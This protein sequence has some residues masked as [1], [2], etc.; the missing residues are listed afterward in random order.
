MP[1]SIGIDRAIVL[2]GHL[3]YRPFRGS[4]GIEDE[5][6]AWVGERPLRAGDAVE[7]IDAAGKILMP[8]L[9]NGHCH[10]ELAFARGMGD[11]LTL[12]EQNERFGP[13]RWFRDLVDDDDRFAS[14]C[15]TYCEALLSGTTF[16]CENMFWS[17]GERSVEAMRSVG[18][19]GALTE[20]VRHDFADP[21]RLLDDGELS[22]LATRAR[23]G[24]LVPL[25]GGPSEEDFEPGR[26]RRVEEKRSR[27]DLLQTCHLAETRWRVD[28][29]ERLY[30]RTPIGF[31]EEL[32]CLG[33]RLIGSHVVHATEEDVALLA[34]RG[35]KVVNTPLSEMKIA[36]GIAPVP[37]LLRAGVCVSLGTDGALWNNSNDLFREMKGLALVQTVRRGIRSLGVA[38]VLD[39][40]TVSGARVFGL[41]REMGTVEVGKRAD[42]VLLDAEQAHLSPLRLGAHENVA[43]TVVFCAT[44][45][46]V[47]DVLVGGRPAVRERRIQGVDLADIRRKVAATSEKVAAAL[48]S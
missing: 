29:I 12:A 39:M 31:L 40:A 13:S 3:R 17:L 44:G 1:F 30:G 43:S 11:D 8:G 41:E 10:G 22:A 6:I 21:D 37:E 32:G 7:R 5:R 18:I 25:L 19:R 36:D 16:L 34:A 24:G 28:R 9:V 45:G 26:L 23:A 2:S 27:L 38:D 46:D 33:E 20:D 42:L 35:V 48:N 47:T 4:V 14:R 15:L